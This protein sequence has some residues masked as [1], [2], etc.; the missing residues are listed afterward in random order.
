MREGKVLNFQQKEAVEYGDGPLLIIAG[1]GT[2]KTTAITERIKY[3]IAS[4]RAKPSEILAL[5]FTDKAAREMEERV[6]VVMPYGYILM[7]IMTFHSF[8]EKVLR[9]EAIH[10]GLD[11][12]F[13]LMTEAETELFLRNR[14]FEF[15]LSYFR[16]LGNP[17]KF[18]NGMITHFSRLKDEDISYGEY[19]NWVK[20]K[21]RKKTDS[22]KDEVSKWEELAEAYK[23]YEQL[24]AKEGV[25]D[26]S[27]LISNTLS[28]FRKRRNILKNY[29][30]KFKY[31]LVDE[32]QDTNIAQ[33]ELVMLVAG[34]KANLTVVADDDQSIYRFRGSS[35]SN[36]MQF[37]KRYPKAKL[38]SLTKNYRSSQE[39]LD[40]A[41][42]LII[43]NNPDRLEVKE[44]I[45]KKLKAV[46]KIEGEE[47]VAI[48]E[49]R[50]ENEA[51]S[52][53][54]E[55]IRVKKEK[56]YQWR[57]FAILVRA[58]RHSEFFLRALARHGV[59][60]QFLGPG[61]LFRQKE[62]KDLIAYLKV[63]YNVEDNA[64]MYRVLTMVDFEINSRDLAFVI[65]FSRKKNLSLFEAVEEICGN[66]S[67]K[68]T[69]RINPET[70]EKLCKILKMIYRH[71]K[72]I[73]KETAGQILYYFL[74]DT[75]ILKKLARVGTRSEEERAL[76]IRKFFDKLKT[77][78][79]EHEDSG[80][81]A[82]VDWINL[83]MELGESP[84]A[85]DFDW[86]EENA[87]N[88]LTVHSAKGLEFKVVFLVNL[89]NERF[90]TRRRG[91]Q[92][93]IPDELIKEILPEGD[94]HIQEERRLFY[95]GMTRA[96]DRLYF[97]FSNYYGEGKRERKVSPFV[98]E[99]LG[100]NVLQKPKTVEKNQLSFFDFKKVE[101]E[102]RRKRQSI[103]ILSYSQINSFI[104][105]PLSYR[106]RYILKLPTPVSAAASFGETIHKTMRDWYKLL[107]VGEKVKFEKVLGIYKKNWQDEGY[108]SKEYKKM[109]MERGRKYLED[110]YKREKDFKTKILY[111]EELFKV[112]VS[113][114]LKV[115]G[116]VDRV[117]DLGKGRIEII[118]YKTGKV[119]SQKEVDRDLQMTIYFMA[120]TQEGFLGR[121]LEKIKA[122]FYFFEEG[123]KITTR[124]GKEEIERAKEKIN[125]VR[126]EIEKSDFRPKPGRLCDYCEYRMIC[127]AWE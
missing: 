7:W 17:N 91:E 60:Y 46:R 99:V 61:Q 127:E 86:M 34:K 30:E 111:L 2:G 120:A 80:V 16:P 63:L 93:P 72:L 42:K 105:C 97:S 12:R 92:I 25:M 70:E 43:N 84:L 47:V 35:V 85:S 108:S 33:N 27:D 39:I 67:L 51:E 119:K 82:V 125:E 38:I 66:E 122:S 28:L 69:V 98:M 3:L 40:K 57:D 14:L 109:M 26:F 19:L 114:D 58:N 15:D 18:I 24:K 23:K 68:K 75:G 11:P 44:G 55:I 103:S 56:N 78:E 54:K 52:V 37:K 106:Y 101:K 126:E 9:D 116:R 79:G 48:Y 31:I 49:D 94:S 118:D 29:Q 10:I 77:Y 76:N 83:K 5:T 53:V 71:L 64:S 32:F 13:V 89:V 117:D 88:I 124:R 22:E 113:E 87:V 41:Y 121:E 36:V 73:G 115:V 81:F 21:K 96:M 8:G 65:N 6:D 100:E 1:A 62:V 59:P 50:G 95:V 74:E 104:N 90:P 4:G 110:Y 107:A 20:K 112:P 102:R 45:K 123:K